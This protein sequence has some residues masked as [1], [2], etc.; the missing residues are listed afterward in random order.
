M[1]KLV[2]NPQIEFSFR[3][4]CYLWGMQLVIIKGKHNLDIYFICDH[5]VEKYMYM[6]EIQTEV[7]YESKQG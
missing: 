1:S 3:R 2:F 6:R 5:L 4:R 7:L